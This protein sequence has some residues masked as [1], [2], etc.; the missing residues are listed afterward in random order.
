MRANNMAKRINDQ[1]WSVCFRGVL[2]DWLHFQQGNSGS[3]DDDNDD[4]DGPRC[5]WVNSKMAAEQCQKERVKR[6]GGL[7]LHHHYQTIVAFKKAVAKANVQLALMTETLAPDDPQVVTMRGKLEDTERELKNMK[8][9]RAKTIKERKR[10]YATEVADEQRDL[11][12]KAGITRN[13]LVGPLSEDEDEDEDNMAGGLS[14]MEILLQQPVE[15]DD[16]DDVENGDDNN[17][18]IVDNNNAAGNE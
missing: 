14:V 3:D 17:N 11:L 13:D 10:Q 15:A 1:V 2:T 12:E 5:V 9:R 16:D 4:N 18:N 7:C 6:L 8:D